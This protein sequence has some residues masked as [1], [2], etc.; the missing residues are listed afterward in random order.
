MCLT[1]FGCLPFPHFETRLPHVTGL[2]VK[3]N[4]PLANAE[5]RLS[6]LLQDANCRTPARTATSDKNGNFELEAVSTFRLIKVL[7]GDPIFGW[8]LC[9]VGKTYVGAFG[10]GVGYAP[11]SINVF[12][13]LDSESKT[14]EAESL[15]GKFTDS[16]VCN[17]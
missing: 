13:K 4:R 17:F 2:I 9:V 1:L 12:C 10:G 8:T 11:A 5:L 6:D 7:L 14:I 16:R 3:D 15:P